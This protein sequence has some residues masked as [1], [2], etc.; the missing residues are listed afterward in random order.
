MNDCHPRKLPCDASFANIATADSKV[1]DD[2]TLYREIVGSLIYIMTAT[3]PDLSYVVTR[4]SQFMASPT[5]MHL[6]VAKDV[7]K[8]LK[9]TQNQG[10]K[11][12]KHDEPLIIRG[13]SDSDWGSS[14]DRKSI[15]GYCFKLS[16]N[17]T[18]IS[19]KSKKQQIVAL[20]SCEAEYIALTHAIQEGKF[21]K[22]LLLDL[23]N[24]ECIVHVGVDNQSAMKL[25][26]N[27]VFHQRSKH[28][29]IKYHFIRDEV[30]K[31]IVNL[32]Y[33]QSVDN[34]ADPFTK[35]VS[36]CKISHMIKGGC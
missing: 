19:W 20:S 11:F 32:F 7:L 29:D 30:L 31:G 12:S 18:L 15:S 9:G 5:S 16:E 27:P 28:I 4:L 21:I 10:L 13:F 14:E 36:Q 26:K 25:A 22:Q 23:L 3:R 33:V 24:T 17:G 35:P 34:L 1:L 6:N 8:Y 2:P